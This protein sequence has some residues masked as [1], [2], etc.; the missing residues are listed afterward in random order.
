MT[1]ARMATTAKRLEFVANITDSKKDMTVL[2]NEF[3]S[4][5]GDFASFT[6]KQMQ[7]PILV[8]QMG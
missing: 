4:V 8:G 6:G 5:I 1:K 2:V 7:S 3:S